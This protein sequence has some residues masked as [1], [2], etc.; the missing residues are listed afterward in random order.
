ME[1]PKMVA[2]DVMIP[3]LRHLQIF[4][5]CLRSIENVIQEIHNGVGPEIFVLHLHRAYE[6]LGQVLGQ[7]TGEDVLDQIFDRFCIGK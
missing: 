3:Q 5:E 1:D 2:G 6:Q 7:D 4:S